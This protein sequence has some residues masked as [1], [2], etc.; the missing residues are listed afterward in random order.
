MPRVAGNRRHAHPRG[1]EAAWRQG[2]GQHPAGFVRGLDA[3]LHH[4]V[5]TKP[6]S[7]DL[8]V[9]GQRLEFKQALGQH[10]EAI[11]LLG[12]DAVGLAITGFDQPLDLRIDFLRGRRVLEERQAGARRAIWIWRS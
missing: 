12:E 3:V 7:M 8:D 11:A 5:G 4:R 9:A 6:G 10:F 2:P 1:P